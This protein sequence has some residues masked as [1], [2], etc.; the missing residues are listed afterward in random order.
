MEAPQSTTQP[1][2]TDEEKSN[3]KPRDARL[4]HA[5]L[6]AQ[7]VTAYQDRVPVMLV[8]FA[9]RYTRGVLSDAAALSAEGY[10]APEVHS[11]SKGAQDDITMTSLR[12]AVASRQI[13]QFQ[14]SLGKPDLSEMAV[15]TNR[16]GLPRVD[17]EFG[18]R[19]PG[20][21]HLFTGSGFGVPEEWEED[22]V[23]DEEEVVEGLETAE[24]DGSGILDDQDMDEDEFEEVMGTDQKMGGT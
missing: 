24:G 22:M 1:A 2:P 5:L 11:K 18:V 9:Y 16:A 20:E 14:P 15:D 10:G 23:V 21:R 7:G 8:D 6:S 12:L 19:L 13:S 4:I 3:P 17:R